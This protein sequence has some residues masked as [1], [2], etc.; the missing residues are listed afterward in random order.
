MKRTTAKKQR[1]ADHYTTRAKKENYPA[2]SV[3]KLQEIQ[4][5]YRIIKPG[6]CVLDLGCAPGAWLRFAAEATHR[7][8][9]VI[10]IDLKPITLA[11]PP[12][13]TTWVADIRRLDDRLTAVIGAGVNVV[14]CDAAPATTGQKDV[15]AARSFELC[16]AALNIAVTHLT[17]GGH[18]V[19][20][21]FQGEDSSRFNQSVKSTFCKTKLFK[22]QSSRKSSKEIYVIAMGKQ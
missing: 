18:F 14:I 17:T 15:D 16:Q 3:Y 1:W 11:L 9:R 13:V 7:H 4:R 2:R 6:D 10:G 22:P 12:N 8:G 20:K 19:C 21:K 5:R